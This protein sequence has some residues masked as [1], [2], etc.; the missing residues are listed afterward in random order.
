M[1]FVF[2]SALRETVR[3]LSPEL[4]KSIV[5]EAIV[6]YHRR[7]SGEQ[8]GLAFATALTQDSPFMDDSFYIT[9]ISECDIAPRKIEVAVSSNTDES[10]LMDHS[11]LSV[12]EY[13][14]NHFK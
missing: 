12:D 3:F 1:D 13:L 2:R 9:T 10:R 8:S 7:S 11:F 14:M 4:P 6:V 5:H